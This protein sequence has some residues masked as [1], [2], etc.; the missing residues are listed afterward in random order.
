[1]FFSRRLLLCFQLKIFPVGSLTLLQL[2][3]CYICLSAGL[4][5]NIK[6]VT[7]LK[8]LTTRPSFDSIRTRARTL[9]IP[10]TNTRLNSYFYFT[11]VWSGLVVFPWFL[12]LTWI[13]VSIL[14]YNPTLSS[15]WVWLFMSYSDADSFKVQF[16]FAFL[17][18]CAFLYWRTLRTSSLWDLAFDSRG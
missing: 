14:T 7:E 6:Q 12:Q 3:I 1:M 16:V 11:A 4:T 8:H 9:I 2:G 10:T 15:I 5:R 18:N 13:W 17:W